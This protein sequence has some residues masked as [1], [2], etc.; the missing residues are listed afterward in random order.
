[1]SNESAIRVLRETKAELEQ[2]LAG[3]DLALEALGARAEKSA[4]KK[5]P[6]APIQKQRPKIG[7][8]LRHKAIADE[9][10][11]HL[12]DDEFNAS[13]AVEIAQGVSTLWSTIEYEAEHTT[14][15]TPRNKIVSVLD[16]LE[17]R[18]LLEAW[19]DP[20]KYER[21]ADRRTWRKV[22]S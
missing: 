6:P 3:I 9:L 2:Q 4:P 10:L 20:E 22:R 19:S 17:R 8:R 14:T 12:P 18:G 1:M 16:H 15:M 13:Q 21:Q 11:P 7:M 5:P